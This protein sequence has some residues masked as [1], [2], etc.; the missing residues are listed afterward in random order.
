MIVDG[1]EK[2]IVNSLLLSDGQTW[3]HN[4]TLEASGPVENQKVEI[5]LYKG[6]NPE[7]YL[8]LHLWLDA[9]E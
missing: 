3:S 9:N 4:F 1:E 2:Q 5:K 7:P 6:D 8:S